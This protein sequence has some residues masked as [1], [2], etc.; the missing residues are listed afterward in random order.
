MTLQISNFQGG[1]AFS[2]FK[3]R[4]LLSRL[5]AE[6]D[7]LESL[8][9]SHVYLLASEHKLSTTDTQRL[10]QLLDAQPGLQPRGAAAGRCAPPVTRC[11]VL[12]A[13]AARRRCC[14]RLL[15]ERAPHG[16]PPRLTPHPRRAR[17]AAGTPWRRR[18]MP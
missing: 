3:T 5:Q 11:G 16:V 8:Q 10:A 12:P 2:P 7:A 13:P 14:R 4:R 6:C 9:A 17:A 1:S 18:W 15:A